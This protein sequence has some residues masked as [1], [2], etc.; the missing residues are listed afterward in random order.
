MV[1]K[2][3]V[4]TSALVLRMKDDE[5]TKVRGFVWFRGGWRG[6]I[7]GAAMGQ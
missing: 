7:A 4:S 5:C 2:R 3:V 6:L 1:V